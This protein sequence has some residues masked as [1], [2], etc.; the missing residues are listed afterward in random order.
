MPHESG[1]NA[2]AVA[3]RTLHKRVVE[4][5]DNGVFT[6]HLGRRVKAS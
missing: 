4:L 2:E 6:G 5:K 1:A 3:A